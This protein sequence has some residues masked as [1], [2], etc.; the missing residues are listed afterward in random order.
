MFSITRTYLPTLFL[1]SVSILFT[2]TTANASEEIGAEDAQALVQPFYD[3]LSG[4]VESDKAFVNMSANWQSYGSDTEFRTVEETIAAIDG[5]RANVVPDLN[6]R[7]DDVIST[8]NFIVVRG[9]G[10]GTP[11]Q[12]FLGVP[13][14][15]KEFSIMSIDIHKV[16]DG[17]VIATWHVENW[18]AAMQQLASN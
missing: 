3:Y 6:W 1:V 11:A 18:A 7:I 2:I 10:S 9:E 4:K 14:S 16:V 17:V 5:L 12:S 8:E 15:G 13:P